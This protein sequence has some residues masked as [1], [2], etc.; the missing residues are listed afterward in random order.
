M[1]IFALMM[2]GCFFI[3]KAS[4]AQDVQI[5][6]DIIDN[7]SVIGSETS[8]AQPIVLR[9]PQP[10]KMEKIKLIPPKS[11]KAKKVVEPKKQ[12][13]AIT[14]KPATKI[15]AVPMPKI[16]KQEIQAP[17]KVEK[18]KVKVP[19]ASVVDKKTEEKSAAFPKPVARPKTLDVTPAMQDKPVLPMPNA[20]KVTEKTDVSTKT[21]EKSQPAMKKES[22]VSVEVEKTEVKKPEIKK[23]SVPVK[24]SEPL[25]IIKDIPPKEETKKVEQK[26][27]AVAPVKA[28]EVKKQEA[29]KAP[30]PAKQT[31]PLKIIKDIPPKEETKKVEQ[32]PEAVAPV[33]AQEVK[34]TEVKTEAK[35]ETNE[36]TEKQPAN[37][38]KSETKVEEKV[39]DKKPIPAKEDL[40]AKLPSGSV[41][42]SL[43]FD[44]SSTNLNAEL[45]A[46]INEKVA[47]YK[48]DT[49]KAFRI[50]GYASAHGED[51]SARRFSLTRAVNTRFALLDMDIHSSRIEIQALGDKSPDDVRDKVDIIIIEK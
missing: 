50:M 36:V 13:K 31:E 1:K 7:I 37:V 29:K 18:A 25:K 46:M 2:I 47:P 41:L 20:D 40:V 6:T 5:N 51:F 23:A 48:D 34:K 43:V 15:E 12:V 3:S 24:K 42:V 30:V 39:E 27:E 8:S 16:T 17:A 26:P 45:V 44:G 9:P 38:V 11:A 49:S 22:V 28:Q 19:V 35:T 33:K 21:E 4:V 32:K 10:Q 14:V